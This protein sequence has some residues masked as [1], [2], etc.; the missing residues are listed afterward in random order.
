MKNFLSF[1]F[2]A[3]AGL[4]IVGVAVYATVGPRLVQDIKQGV[5][6]ETDP[7]DGKLKPATSGP[8]PKIEVDNAT[9][10][11]GTME[12]NT[13]TEHTF[14]IKNVGEAPLNFVNGG[15]TCQCTISDLSQDEVGVLKPGETKNVT[16]TIAPFAETDTFEKYA[17]IRSNDPK[18]EETRL[19][20]K[21]IVTAKYGVFPKEVWNVGNIV[22]GKGASFS[23]VIFSQVYDKFELEKLESN[24]PQMT[25]TKEPLQEADLTELKAK[26]GYQVNV[27][28]EP[29]IVVG[30]FKARVIYKLD[31]DESE[32]VIDVTAYR[33]GQLKMRGEGW[34]ALE[35]LVEFGT[36]KA[37]AGKEITLTTFVDK[38]PTFTGPF[39]MTKVESDPS[40]IDFKI[41]P[42]EA[43]GSENVL[44]YKVT[45]KIPPESTTDVRS[46]YNPAFLTVK[47]NH[48]EMPEI[49]F[50]IRFSAQ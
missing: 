13:K 10:D 47:T 42:F 25:V 17:I 48:P 18:S 2:P 40:Y 27:Q 11:F 49:R 28:I 24:N 30:E 22:E 38:T 44:A 46:S 5:G 35:K 7:Y 32:H 1:V 16:L 3:L 21:G 20:V 23:G 31:V 8:Q 12:V 19:I 50:K 4:I 36:F 39:E 14:V 45:F 15:S 43:G 33:A 26:A 29:N 34:Y 37:S 9:F 6:V 41:E